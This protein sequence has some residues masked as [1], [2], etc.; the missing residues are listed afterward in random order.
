M[1]DIPKQL[2]LQDVSNDYK[3]FVDKFKPKKTTDD[4]YTPPNIYDVVLAWVCNRYKVET[5]QVV[6]PF[7][8]GCDYERYEYAEDSVVVDNP[9][10]SIIKQIIDFYNMH[11][12]PFFLFAPHL[13]NFT[14]GTAVCH[15]IANATI[16]YENGAKVSTSFVTNMDD[17]LV[18]ADPELYNAICE[19]NKKNER[20]SKKA[21]PSYEY[22]P[23]VLTAAMVGKIVNK[24]VPYRLR[25]EEACF[26][27]RIDAQ[28][29]IGKV[30][31]GGGFLISEKAAA[32]KA[33]A[34]KAERY[35]FELSEREREI[36]RRLGHE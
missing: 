33:A 3:A 31:F 27:R 34:E 1:R 19:E 30:L 10:F 12:I 14:A 35:I 9:P 20:E 25:K 18:L 4:C 32:E 6:R 8:P 28:I 16:T 11:K 29:P 2:T 22:P 26:V 21:L 15:V 17:L 7:Y 36:I 5:S 24:G 23:N 13:T